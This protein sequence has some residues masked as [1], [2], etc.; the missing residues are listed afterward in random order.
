M[1]RFAFLAGFVLLTTVIAVPILLLKKDRGLPGGNEEN[2][3][4]DIND[5]MASEGL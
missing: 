1:K 3:R 5:Y 2:I 4:Y